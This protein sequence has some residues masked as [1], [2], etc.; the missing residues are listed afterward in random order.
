MVLGDHSF[1]GTGEPLVQWKEDFSFDGTSSIKETYGYNS[2][3][4]YGAMFLTDVTDRRG[5]TTHYDVES[6]IGHITQITY[7]AT[8]GSAAT[9]QYQYGEPN[10][11]ILTAAADGGSNPN[12]NVVSDPH[13][14]YYVT[15]VIDQNGHQTTYTRDH[16]VTNY[17]N[18]YPSMTHLVT[19]VD[20]AQ[21]ASTPA[22]FETF[23]Y[24]SFGQVTAHQR[25][26]SA[27]EYAT[28]DSNGLLTGL[29]N[30][31]TD[32]A[33]ASPSDPHTTYEYY[34][35]SDNWPGRLKT[36]TTPMGFRTT[37]EYD[38]PTTCASA[39]DIN[40]NPLP[41][42]GRGLITK[43]SYPDDTTIPG[44]TSKSFSYDVYGNKLTDADELNHT[45]SYTYDDFSRVLTTS[46]PLT[47][48]TQLDYTPPGKSPYS[49]T[50]DS[51]YKHT[52][53]A[54]IVTTQTYDANFR[55][56]TKTEGFGTSDAATTQY[57]WD[58]NGNQLSI[59]DP[60]NNTTSFI[61]D[62]RNRKT[63]ITEPLNH[64]TSSVYDQM[65]NVLSITRS[66]NTVETKTY[67]A[68]NRVLTDTIPRNN[69]S[70]L[71]TTAFTY[72]PS[73]TMQKVIDA[74]LH[75]TSFTYWPDDSKQQMTFD[76]G[77]Y[78]PT[79]MIAIIV[80]RRERRRHLP[81]LIRSSDTMRGI[82]KLSSGGERVTIPVIIP[83]T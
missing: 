7:P 77:D 67:D 75:V 54:G 71:M 20:Y 24:N 2:P 47:D 43:I 78:G 83:T 41:C 81:R 56:L 32:P 60:R 57:T 11:D 59:I 23:G 50:T 46:D 19:R 49:H 40:G 45:T 25:R 68:M 52:T 66:D 21:D 63:S 3:Y 12:P 34:G 82:E 64:V 10:D 28:Y 39:V 62:A 55:V 8:N 1:V 44:G 65:G 6:Q 79:S 37:Y 76:N 22:S 48:M 53:P 27:F 58:A 18:G 14:P 36:V 16:T 38:L 33:Y 30:P 72:N 9:K 31:T 26:N 61:Y 70:D 73:G 13:N 42:R 5:N 51:V 15:A 29:W 4:A 35:S 69:V 17:G 74:N 80:S